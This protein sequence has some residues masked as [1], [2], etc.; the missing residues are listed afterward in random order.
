[1]IIPLKSLLPTPDDVLNADLETLGGLLLKHLKSCEGASPVYQH[2]GLNR[3]YFLAIRERRNIGL[4]PLP[5]NEPEYGAKQSAVSQAFVEAWDWLVRDGLLI[6]NHQQPAEWYL[7]SR[8]GQKFLELW[9]SRERPE[10][11]AQAGKGQMIQSQQPEKW[12]VFI[13]HASEDKPYVDPLATALRAAGVSVWYDQM[14]LNWGDDLRP[15][16]DNGLINCRFGIVVLSK[17]FLSK[18]KW[19][20]HEL[21][22][23]FAREQAGQKLVLPIWHGIN[24]G[25]LL[26]YSPTLADRLAKIS[27]SDS[28]DDIVKSML[29][30]LGRPISNKGAVTPGGG[31]HQ[32]HQAEQA[33]QPAF[34][35]RRRNAAF[36]EG[37]K[38]LDLWETELLWN[39]AR[40]PQ[41]QILHSDI[42]SGEG[43][44]A[45]DRQ[46]LEGADARSA[47][48][49][50]GALRHLE[51]RGFVEPLSS[52]RDFFKVTSD[53]YAAADNLE[54]FER[55]KA[56][57]IVLRAHYLNAP[58]EERTIACKGIIAM[59]ARYFDDQSGLDGSVMRSLK[60]PRFLLVEG[61]CQRPLDDWS[62]TE[63]EFKDTI[64]G[65]VELF[66][67]DGMKFLPPA[68]LK[69][70]IL[71]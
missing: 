70:P 5:S 2:A 58:T 22:G 47:A 36:S 57:A 51:D 61:I 9:D 26:E 63:A 1:M 38:D 30:L 14:I 25:N 71:D 34:A 65:K 56:G 60:E 35:V 23:L 62:P 66:R 53:G 13:S 68:R 64:T 37:G 10:V 8:K 33:K 43:L 19:T 11:K 48:E 12:D 15:M 69:L 49:W 40:D 32:K 52:D 39:A 21:N 24:R 7:I 3:N 42:L 67:V 27:D 6:R 50:L 17:A 55:W 28:A 20:E 16:I 18:K 31:E 44:R 41:G 45:S 46:F 54:G 4:G 29:G 59:P